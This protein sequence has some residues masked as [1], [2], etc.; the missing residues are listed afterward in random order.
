MKAFHSITRSQLNVLAVLLN[1]IIVLVGL[2]LYGFFRES[3]GLPREIG[4][5]M[6]ASGLAALILVLYQI[7]SSAVEGQDEGVLGVS[8]RMGL[9]GYYSSR[10]AFGFDKSDFSFKGAR[11]IQV[12]ELSGHTLFAGIEPDEWESQSGAG[13]TIQILLQD[14]QYPPGPWTFPNNRDYEEG[15]AIGNDLDEIY[16]FIDKFGIKSEFPRGGYYELRLTRAMPTISYFRIDDCIYWAPYLPRKYGNQ[17]PHMRVDRGGELFDV[18]ERA[19]D[20]MWKMETSR[21][22]VI[23][24]WDERD[25]LKRNWASQIN[26]YQAQEKRPLPAPAQVSK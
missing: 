1:I 18:L 20:L 17:S 2:A 5:G 22:V 6:V 14:P 8:K 13:A 12:L 3:A 9:S 21:E 16:A 7:A 10:P 25:N 19:F 24:D 23:P 26:Q 15:N 4:S 11:T